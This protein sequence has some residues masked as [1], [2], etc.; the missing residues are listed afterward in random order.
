M[1]KRLAVVLWAGWIGYSVWRGHLEII[2]SDVNGNVGS[3]FREC[4]VVCFEVEVEETTDSN[5]VYGKL[6][7]GLS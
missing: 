6:Y 7:D 1:C 3:K 4:D 2:V 5:G